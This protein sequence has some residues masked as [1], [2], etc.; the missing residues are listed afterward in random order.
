[1]TVLQGPIG[2]RNHLERKRIQTL[3]DLTAEKT[4][5]CEEALTK[6]RLRDG[7]EASKLLNSRIYRY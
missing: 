4:Y 3:D 5:E 1:M 7:N 6:D 2:G